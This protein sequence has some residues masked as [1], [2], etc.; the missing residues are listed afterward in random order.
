M[1]AR[2]K[3]INKMK[4]LL[5][6]AVLF[7]ACEKDPMGDIIVPPTITIV[8]QPKDNTNET[9]TPTASTGSPTVT[10]GTNSST[11]VEEDETTSQTETQ[12]S[13]IGLEPKS[14]QELEDEANALNCDEPYLVHECDWQTDYTLFYNQLGIRDGYTLNHPQSYYTDIYDTAKSR[15]NEELEN[16]IGQYPTIIEDNTERGS[17][18]FAGTCG[19]SWHDSHQQGGESTVGTLVHEWGHVW[20]SQMNH[21]LI[22]EIYDA[23]SAQREAYEAGEGYDQ[24]LSSGGKDDP[25]LRWR[26]LYPYQLSNDGEYMACNI[27]AYFNSPLGAGS[28]QSREHLREQDP[29]IF[30]LIERLL[31]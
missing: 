4:K 9:E 19:T 1:W 7:A 14:E 15:I 5:I 24:I 6:L 31:N 30:A 29:V 13:T 20:H 21:C 28:I 25:E 18:S 16:V 2:S 12:S 10:T 27:A 8:E 23:W 3:K 26:G 22:I 11:S 17:F